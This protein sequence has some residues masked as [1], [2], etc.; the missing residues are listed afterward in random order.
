[1]PA[2][3]SQSS[4]LDANENRNELISN[5][6]SMPPDVV[7]VTLPTRE[8][9]PQDWLED[10]TEMSGLHFTYQ[11]GI[12]SRQY[13]MVE[14]LGGGVAL[15][16]FD[17]DGDMD[18][19]ITGGGEIAPGQIPRGRPG[20]LFR[21]EGDLRFTNVT[22]AVGLDQP[23]DYS[24]GVTVGDYDRDGWPDLFVTAYGRSRLYRNLDGQSFVDQTAAADL[25]IEG[26]YT[27]SVFL[28]FD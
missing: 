24:H 22:A 13:A 26:W 17:R 27:S 18:V 23:G 6:D 28:D 7:T 20:A 9:S 10:V 19:Y 21:N 12:E 15:F 11:T 16:D 1:M 14:E 4:V 2:T 8:A 3:D 25:D 5:K